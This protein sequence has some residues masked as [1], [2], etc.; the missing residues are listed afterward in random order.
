MKFRQLLLWALEDDRWPSYEEYDTVR[1][2]P[3]APIVRPPKPVVSIEQAKEAESPI[4]VIDENDPFGR[5]AK[6]KAKAV[7]ALPKFAPRMRRAP[8]EHVVAPPE[9][10][11]TILH[12][13]AK[14][15]DPSRRTTEAFC[16]ELKS[17]VWQK[18][19]DQITPANCTKLVTGDKS[20][21]V[22]LKSKPVVTSLRLWI[23]QNATEAQNL[24]ALDWFHQLDLVLY[25]NRI[26]M[27][28]APLA[29]GQ[30]QSSPIPP[31]SHPPTETSNTLSTQPA[32]SVEPA[33]PVTSIV[34]E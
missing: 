18:I 6:A 34:I 27:P 33:I 8:S 13:L 32:P 20:C 25:P 3:L 24:E 14:R 30:E 5:T 31:L 9:V 7:I 21:A 26:P 29:L 28:P 1:A 4:V 17:L 16:E 19:G 22:L 10:R 2:N 11:A 23:A 15:D 12:A